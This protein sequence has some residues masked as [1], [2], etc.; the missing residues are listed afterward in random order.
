MGKEIRVQNGSGEMCLEVRDFGV[1]LCGSLE[2]SLCLLSWERGQME[3]MGTLTAH[4]QIW[5]L[6]GRQRIKVAL[7]G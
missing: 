5:C 6:R 3:R 7:Q 1:K 4:A 2:A